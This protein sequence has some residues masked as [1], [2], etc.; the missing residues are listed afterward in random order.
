MD[1]K[2]LEKEFL[3]SLNGYDTHLAYKV[4]EKK[5]LK[6]LEKEKI[7]EKELRELEEFCKKNINV[8]SSFW[9]KF[10]KFCPDEE[11]EFYF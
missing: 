4:L 7:N 10:Y 8:K 9:E 3:D 6:I 2:Q 1:L 11:E 5:V